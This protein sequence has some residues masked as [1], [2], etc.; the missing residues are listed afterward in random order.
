MYWFQVLKILK[1][2]NILK[3]YFFFPITV[4]GFRENEKLRNFPLTM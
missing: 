1:E 3:L 2:E 4:N